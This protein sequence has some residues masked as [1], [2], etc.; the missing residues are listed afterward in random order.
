M[1]HICPELLSLLLSEG[2]LFHSTKHPIRCAPWGA[3]RRSTSLLA[4]IYNA[5][6]HSF[7]SRLPRWPQTGGLAPTPFLK[8]SLFYPFQQ[9]EISSLRFNRLRTTFPQIP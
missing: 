5:R 7:P 6:R 3:S 8:G 9:P 1:K 2:S 4:G